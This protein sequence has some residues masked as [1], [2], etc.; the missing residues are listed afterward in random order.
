[1]RR[2]V[3]FMISSMRGGGSERQTLMLLR[4]LNRERFAPQLYLLEPVGDLL[5]QVP[6]DVLI[7]SFHDKNRSSGLYFPGR[8]LHQQIAHLRQTIAAQ[9]IQVIYDRTFHMSLIAA[10]AAKRASVPRVSTIVSPPELALP[11]V[12]TRF[13]GLKRFRLSRAYHQSRA[14]IAVSEQ[15]AESAR[16]YY[17]LAPEMVEVIRNPVDAEAVRNEA[18]NHRIQRD[19]SLTLACVGRMTTEKGHADLISALAL[20]ES[21]WPAHQTPITV[22]MIGD[23]PLREQLVRQAEQ[24]LKRH[25]VVFLGARDDAPAWIQASDALVLPSHFEGLPNVVLE[26]MALR[27]PVIATRAGGT[28]E[29]QQEEPTILW[30]KPRQPSTLAGA[31]LQFHVDRPAAQQRVQAAVRL[32]ESRHDV[33]NAIAR[34]ETLLS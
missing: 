13:I 25:R 15:A 33:R 8:I 22:W 24:Q 23:G 29:L 6:A 14:V 21:Q 2:S 3:L 27:T 26:A 12:E 1:M 30:A 11:L 4:H 32:I 31:I 17:G 9:Q 28:I 10:P 20:T 16:R 5:P 18:A 19:A 34:V 7:H